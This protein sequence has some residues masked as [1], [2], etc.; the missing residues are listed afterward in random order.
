[1]L[2]DVSGK[3]IGA[4]LVMTSMHSTCRALLRHTQPLE[5]IALVLN[6]SIIETTRTQTYVTLLAI[7]VDSTEGKL[8]CL[9]AGH[10]PP[11][12]IDKNG[13]SL[14]LDQGGGLPIGLF[15]DLKVSTET[16][17]IQEG[18]SLVLYTDGITEAQNSTG[19]HFGL[20]RLDSIALQHHTETARH[21]H[22]GIRNALRQF[23]GE[24]NP[25]DDTTLVVVKF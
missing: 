10:H 19:E 21:I 7:L 2:G 4:A 14:W 23:T 1:M 9:R 6:E 5:R 22:D 18:S 20:E 8:Y 12:F 3:G 24:S 25:T 11:L 17:A 15:S 13:K 16:Y